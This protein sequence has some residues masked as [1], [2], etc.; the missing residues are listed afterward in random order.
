ML[1]RRLSYFF[2]DQF[3]QAVFIVGDPVGKLLFNDPPMVSFLLLHFEH[4]A[5]AAVVRHVNMEKVIGRAGQQPE[6]EFTKAI[7]G[8][9]ELGEVNVSCE[10]EIH[11]SSLCVPNVQ[12][13][14]FICLRK[15]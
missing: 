3:V 11:T 1:N 2:F 9:N 5:V 14:C 15:S 13:S 8:F 7:G 6:I 10:G 4:D 12:G